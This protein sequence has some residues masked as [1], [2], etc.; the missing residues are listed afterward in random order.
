V[1]GVLSKYKVGS[2]LS[3]LLAEQYSPQKLREIDST[4]TLYGLSSMNEF[5]K[6]A[7]FSIKHNK[8]KDFAL[9]TYG[10]LSTFE[11]EDNEQYE[12]FVKGSFMLE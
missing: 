10:H 12:R 11:L 4:R 3:P 2:K 9:M 1:D 6:K 5:Y 7:V 8:G